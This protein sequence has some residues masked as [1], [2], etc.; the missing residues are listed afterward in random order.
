MSIYSISW[1]SGSSMAGL[2]LILV[3]NLDK[4]KKLKRK[5]WRW[6]ELSVKQKKSFF[7]WVL[8]TF[9]VQAALELVMNM[10]FNHFMVS[11]NVDNVDNIVVVKPDLE[12]LS[13]SEHLRLFLVLFYFYFWRHFFEVWG[14]SRDWHVGTWMNIMR[15]RMKTKHNC[16]LNNWKASCS[17][18]KTVR[19]CSTFN[20][21]QHHIPHFLGG[22]APIP[23]FG[24]I[25]SHLKFDYYYYCWRRT[26]GHER[27]PF[28]LFLTNFSTLLT[29]AW[30]E[31][32][33]W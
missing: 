2:L 16:E 10:V 17:K 5:F 26:L 9:L 23:V 30:Q 25:S 13:L 20:R 22:S 14:L 4:K 7:I 31:K 8:S 12:S 1:Q 6:L 3:T 18:N 15:E 19:T 32:C 21:Q 11:N 28:L 24:T 27:T 33:P 29:I